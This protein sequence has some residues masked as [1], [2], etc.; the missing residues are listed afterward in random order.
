MYSGARCATLDKI[1]T[2]CLCMMFLKLRLA[3]SMISK[4]FPSALCLF[5]LFF[6]SIVTATASSS[7]PDADQSSAP[8][9]RTIPYLEWSSKISDEETEESRRASQRLDCLMQAFDTGGLEA[10]VGATFD[11]VVSQSDFE[12]Q[13][14]R[15][16]ISVIGMVEVLKGWKYELSEQERSSIYKKLIA[17]EDLYIVFKSFSL[18]VL[19]E[20]L[21]LSLPSI[22]QLETL[23]GLYKAAPWIDQVSLGLACEFSL[24]LGGSERIW[25]RKLARTALGFEDFDFSEKAEALGFLLECGS[26]PEKEAALSVIREVMETSKDDEELLVAVGL[27]ANYDRKVEVDEV[28]KTVS[29]IEKAAE[30][31]AKLLDCLKVRCYIKGEERRHGVD[32]LSNY[33]EGVYGGGKK[34]EKQEGLE[35]RAQKAFSLLVLSD[36]YEDWALTEFVC[37]DTE[38]DLAIEDAAGLIDVLTEVLPESDPRFINVVEVGSSITRYNNNPYNAHKALLSKRRVSV[39][40]N[41]TSLSKDGEELGFNEQFIKT[42]PENPTLPD[43]KE[44]DLRD[45]WGGLDEELEEQSQSVGWERL[46]PFVSQ[47]ER[48]EMEALV[49]HPYVREAFSRAREGQ[50]PTSDTR[51]IHLFSVLDYLKN[52]PKSRGADEVLSN[53]SLQILQFFLNLRYCGKDHAIHYFDTVKQGSGGAASYSEG[54]ID[55][56]ARLDRLRGCLIDRMRQNRAKLLSTRSAFMR[57]ITGTTEQHPE[58]DWFP[59]VWDYVR[60]LIGVDIGLMPQDAPIPFNDEGSAVSGHLRQF[61]KQEVLDAFYRHYTLDGEI[62]NLT[63][64]INGRL[65]RGDDRFYNDI[66]QVLGGSEGYLNL[67]EDGKK[68]R[69]TR[70]GTLRLMHKLGVVSS[71]KK[72]S[73]EG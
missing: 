52:L 68:P 13:G 27:L 6:A 65:G 15:T 37:A 33:I 72:V 35:K 30:S 51:V 54:A 71:K 36:L 69:I 45:V 64:A 60:S 4:K 62:D 8:M 18:G 14:L 73:L 16:M 46:E 23:F 47:E 53:R 41:M 19:R 1:W 43:V 63:D 66:Y 31:P 28:L 29:R 21:G 49:D 59:Y 58:I 67:V 70:S 50:Q 25:C 24:V 56:Q 10:L 22:Q 12:E 2:F 17:K 57:E 40:H 11:P 55:M 61:S 32:A 34:S 39:K 26:I 42:F 48:A 7:Y 9:L 38:L 20:G 44:E 5:V 3:M